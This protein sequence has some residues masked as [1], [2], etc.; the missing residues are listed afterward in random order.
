V[1]AEV[2]VANKTAIALAA[3]SAVTVTAP[4]GSGEIQSKV[5]N[6]ANKLFQLAPGLP[7]G[8][9]FYGNAA[10]ASAPLESLIK[11]FRERVDSS[12]VDCLDDYAEQFWE[13]LESQ[14]LEL[15]PTVRDLDT[16]RLIRTH[17]DYARRLVEQ[18]LRLELEAGSRRSTKNI[19][20]E[21]VAKF[22]EAVR[23]L[24]QS[25]RTTSRRVTEVWK[26]IDPSIGEMIRYELRDID[27]DDATVDRI[28]RT[29]RTALARMPEYGGYS[30]IVLG[31]FAPGNLYP[32]LKHFR[33]GGFLGGRLNLHDLH[34]EHQL[35]E[36]RTVYVWPFAQ[37]EMVH[38]FMQGID[39]ELHALLLGFM[40][41]SLSETQRAVIAA[42][43]AKM[44]TA[45]AADLRKKVA[46]VPK[47]VVDHFSSAIRQFQFS[48]Y[49]KPVLDALAN[50]PKEHLAE[51]A[52]SLVNLTSFRRRVS[53]DLETVGGDIDV[54]V[55]SAGDGFIWIK[56][57]HYFDADLNP[58]FFARYR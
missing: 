35:D 39:P 43:G 38:A 28:K 11:T 42:A 41:R 53:M 7:V 44:S 40:E 54:A 36:Q 45:D 27:P 37:D 21:G 14:V 9:M 3:D 55:I 26:P 33:I 56:R 15:T 20:R 19:V 10:L 46:S 30:G 18:N 57:K 50:M 1:T 17:V 48:V 4:Y 51:A 49:T 34:D 52:E 16:L 47:E 31:G 58:A 12:S 24:P 2:A 6:G 22:E 25:T 29:I 8:I 32:S 23:E 13:F 5:I